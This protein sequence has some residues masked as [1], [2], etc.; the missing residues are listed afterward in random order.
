MRKWATI[1]PPQANNSSVSEKAEKDFRVLFLKRISDY[2]EDSNEQK[3]EKST[4]E[5][6]K[7]ASKKG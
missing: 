2:I 1:T 3:T 5:P 4:Q 7:K 6:N